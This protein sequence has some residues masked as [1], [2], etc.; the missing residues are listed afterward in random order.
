MIGYPQSAQVAVNAL[1]V[2]DAA[3]I[4]LPFAEAAADEIVGNVLYAF[5]PGDTNYEVVPA[6]AGSL[7][8]YYGYWLYASQACTLSFP[9]PSP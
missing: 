8:P 9:A 3:R 2:V 1:T 7:T 5:Q 4:S 6:A